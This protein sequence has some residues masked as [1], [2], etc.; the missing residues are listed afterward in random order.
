MLLR[1]AIITSV[2]LPLNQNSWRMPSKGKTENLLFPD[3]TLLGAL[4]TK[5]FNWLEQFMVHAKDSTKWVV[6]LLN[7]WNWVLTHSNFMIFDKIICLQQSMRKNWKIRTMYDFV[8]MITLLCVYVSAR[9]WLEHLSLS[10]IPLCS[11]VS[12]LQEKHWHRKLL[13]NWA[14]F[15]YL[16][17]VV[18]NCRESWTETDPWICYFL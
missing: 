11:A 12:Y 9:L 16:I 8:S 5:Y 17:G 1:F 7:A 2:F 13:I 3:F 14:S 10:R 18:P 6:D 15:L 4:F